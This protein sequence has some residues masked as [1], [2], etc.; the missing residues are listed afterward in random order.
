MFS[1]GC[2]L[3]E[4]FTGDALFQTHDNLEHLAMMEVVM[5]AMPVRMINKSRYVPLFLG[6]CLRLISGRVKKPEFFKNGKIDFPNPTVS[7]SSRKYVKT[8]RS[9]VQIIPPTSS[10][11]K[12]FLDLI[13][14]LLDFDPETRCNVQTALNHPYLKVAT[15]EPPTAA[16][17]P[18][19]SPIG[20]RF[21]DM[22]DTA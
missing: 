3:V 15:A 12:M 4:F 5:G 21:A 2:I 11:N 7:R 16:V 18:A 19:Y 20:G 10:H 14:R 1:I 9:L 17:S 13:E 6:V 8:M 22:Q